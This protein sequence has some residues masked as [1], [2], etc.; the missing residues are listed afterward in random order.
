MDAFEEIRENLRQTAVLL[1]QNAKDSAA[2]QVKER[3]RRARHENEM[4][5]RQT[6]HEN[7][8]AKWRA[9]ERERQTRHENEM[10]KWRVEERE[11]QTRHENEMAERQTRH[12][13]EIAK[14]QTRHENE[15]AERQTRH[16]NEIAKWRA[17][18]LERWAR[19]DK[20]QAEI[21]EWQ[22]E[23]NKLHAETDRKLKSV[24]QQLGSIGI[25]NGAFA[26]DSFYNW[27]EETQTLGGEKYDIVE[28]NLRERKGHSEFDIFMHNGAASV[29]IEVKYR[30]HPNDIPKL[31]ANKPVAFRRIYTEYSHH[32]L[33]LGLASLVISE[34]LKRM[35]QEAGIFL[36]GHKS[37]GYEVVN[38]EVQAF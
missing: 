23:I 28:R 34:N 37:T 16:E 13:N 1:A 36:L 21:K 15:M 18:D 32:K 5:E 9:E 22:V 10:A 29:I 25:N 26:E 11:R 38:E 31:L 2:W 33:Y 12:E 30:A 14:R 35:A 7:E 17:E 20:W 3:E 24:G 27:L 6:R 4:A 8:I 19:Q